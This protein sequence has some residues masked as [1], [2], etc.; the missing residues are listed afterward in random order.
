[1]R[2]LWLVCAAQVAGSLPA[3]A[4]GDGSPPGAGDRPPPGADGGADYFPAPTGRDFVITAEGERTSKQIAIIASLAGTALAIGGVGLYYNLDSRSAAEAVSA[5]TFTHV[6]WSAA[7]Q[8]TYDRA[9]S[10]GAKAAVFYSL[11]G[12]VLIGAVVAFIV[13]DPKTETTVIH[14]HGTGKPSPTIAPT[15]GGAVLGGTWEF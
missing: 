10:S 5:K 11:G 15:S 7:D 3:R 2:L 12:A 13:T 4:D 14:P 6:V 8:A 9:N 1:M